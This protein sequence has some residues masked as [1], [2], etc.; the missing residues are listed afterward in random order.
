MIGWE[1]K[2]TCGTRGAWEIPFMQLKLGVYS[3][4][5]ES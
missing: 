3:S 1:L 5:T 2:Q 4:Q